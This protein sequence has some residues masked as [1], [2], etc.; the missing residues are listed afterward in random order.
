MKITLGTALVL[1]CSALSATR[2]QQR[3]RSHGLWPGL[4]ESC[5]TAFQS[6]SSAKGCGSALFN[7]KPIHLGVQFG[8]VPM[9][10]VGVGPT[11]LIDLSSGGVTS[12]MLISTAYTWK[13]FW[14]LS[15]TVKFLPRSH[16]GLMEHE[17]YRIYGLAR[18][19]R[20][21]DDYGEGPTTPRMPLTFGGREAAFGVSARVPLSGT[22]DVGAATELR[23]WEPT[24]GGDDLPSI[25]AAFDEAQAPGMT[26]S[27]SYARV[28]AGFTI[29]SQRIDTYPDSLA[30]YNSVYLNPGTGSYAFNRVDIDLAYGHGWEWQALRLRSR[31]VLT[32][33]FSGDTV[34]FYYQ[35]TLGQ[36]DLDG[37]EDLRG[38]DNYRFRGLHSALV[39]ADYS[40]RPVRNH[41]WFRLIAFGDA[42][43]V[44]MSLSDLNTQH[45]RTDVG[46]GIAAFLAGVE[47]AKVFV[48]HSSERHVILSGSV[49]IG[50]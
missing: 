22:F 40:A 45:I 28:R 10:G 43:R 39:Q 31:L 48:A 42:G 9:S 50:Y 15:D 13:G 25:R 47:R 29:H 18:Y 23:H 14:V 21:L 49:S 8:F 20:A 30:V 19:L 26:R 5:P 11:G 38:Y 37:R 44:A 36:A 2:A 35:P 4:R 33:A 46:A 16:L 7:D 6:F 27:A 41:D 12:F 24:S 17:D 3:E 32:H 1:A 34:P